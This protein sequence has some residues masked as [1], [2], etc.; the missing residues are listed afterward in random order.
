MSILDSFPWLVVPETASSIFPRLPSIQD[1]TSFAW[2]I[3]LTLRTGARV[4]ASAVTMV[5]DPPD[6][7]MTDIPLEIEAMSAPSVVASGTR[8]PPAAYSPS[9]FTG[10]A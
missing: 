10:P 2:A 7:V 1:M 6:A 4:M 5:L 9:I 3:P 8:K